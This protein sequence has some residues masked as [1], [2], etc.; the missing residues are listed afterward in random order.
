MRKCPVCKSKFSKG[1]WAAGMFYMYCPHCNAHL[2]LAIDWRCIPLLALFCIAGALCS[3][4][5]IF[6]IITIINRKL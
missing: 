2:K 5:V 6:K 1:K 3:T 4:H